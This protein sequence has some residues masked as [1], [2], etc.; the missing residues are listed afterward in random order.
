MGILDNRQN[1]AFD[2]RE[3]TFNPTCKEVAISRKR[4]F[5]SPVFRN[6]SAVI[7]AES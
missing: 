3:I 1:Q 5:I 4:E 6:M 7:S 2:R